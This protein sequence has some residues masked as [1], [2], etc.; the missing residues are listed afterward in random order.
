[1]LADSPGGKIVRHRE[2]TT[3]GCDMAL[4]SL[5]ELVSLEGKCAIVMGAAHGFGAAISRR[6]GEAGATVFDG[7]ILVQP[8]EGYV[9]ASGH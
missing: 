6:L 1:M 4:P 8:L 2:A 5:S 3:E 9:P 7:G